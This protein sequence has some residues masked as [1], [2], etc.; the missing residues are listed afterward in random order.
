MTIQK[1]YQ[2]RPASA[3]YDAFSYM[4]SNK[5]E[6]KRSND[7]SVRTDKLGPFSKDDR[8][9]HMALNL[10]DKFRTINC[11]SQQ[12]YAEM[13]IHMILAEALEGTLTKHHRLQGCIYKKELD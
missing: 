2:R 5:L 4:S 6:A 8:F 12:F 1:G 3:D 13:L 11:V 9:K 7:S 10:A